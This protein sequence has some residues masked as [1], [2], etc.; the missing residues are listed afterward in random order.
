MLSVHMPHGGC[1]EENCITE[2][3]LVKIV[4]EEGKKLGQWVRVSKL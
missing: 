2:L 3:A 1:D 4:M